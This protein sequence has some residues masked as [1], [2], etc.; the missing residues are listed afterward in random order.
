M[1]RTSESTRNEDDGRLKLD[2]EM[3]SRREMGVTFDIFDLQTQDLVWTAYFQR[4]EAERGERM[5]YEED[6]AEIEAY[7]ADAQF[8]VNQMIDSARHP[9]P[10]PRSQLLRS[11]ARDVARHLPGGR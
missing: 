7:E 2:I 6:I 3:I 9:E 10:P 1:E 11:F 8:A 4:V 5:T